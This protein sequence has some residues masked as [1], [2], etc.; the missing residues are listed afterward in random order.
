MATG[1]RPSLP[2]TGSAAAATSSA[3][4]EDGGLQHVP[5]RVPHA[6]IAS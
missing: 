5:G 2:I 4:R 6:E 3:K 1:T